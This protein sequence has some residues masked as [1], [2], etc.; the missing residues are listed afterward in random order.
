[1]QFDWRRG[2]LALLF[3][4]SL[5]PLLWAVTPPSAPTA[6]TGFFSFS[7]TPT[8]LRPA[9]DLSW[10]PSESGTYLMAGYRLFRKQGDGPVAAIASTDRALY[11]GS[12]FLDFEGI[13]MGL[14]YLYQVQAVD[15][16]GNSSSVSAL[17]E[18]D[19][20]AL[21]EAQLAPAAPTVF[22]AKAGRFDIHLSWQTP[23]MRADA[24]STYQ[25]YRTLAGMAPE[26]GVLLGGVSLTAFTD[27][28][29]TPG[30]LT[31]YWL[32]SQDVMGRVSPFSASA[33]AAA[34]GT[35]PPSPPKKLTAVAGE[36]KVDLSWEM[37]D[38]GTSP[39]SAYLIRRKAFGQEQW[40]S[41]SAVSVSKTTYAEKDMDAR[42]AWRWQ[43]AALDFEGNTSAPA[44]IEAEA[45]AEREDKANILLMPSAYVA[46]PG[47]DTGGNLNVA[48]SYYI[49]SLY[50]TYDDPELGRTRANVFQPVR[51]GTFT[52]DLKLA[53]LPDTWASP[54]IATGLYTSAIINIGQPT[55]GS[56]QQVGVTSSGD[57]GSIKTLGG[58]YLVGS[59]RLG[60]W[61]T[62]H[63]GAVRGNLADDLSSVAPESWR[64]TLRHMTPSGN[65]PDL[66]TRLVDPSLNVPVD[67]APHLAYV[68]LQLPFVLPLG[69][70]R[71]KSALRAEY[72]TPIFPREPSD[73]LPW[74]LN[75]HFDH[76]PLFGFEFSYFKFY[77]GYQILAF[78]HFHDL[79]WSL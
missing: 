23:A 10:E 16:K 18:M 53:L 5:S 25:V 66:M 20:G 69:F 49:G 1:M 73:K 62:L 31:S 13:K 65:L 21:P 75:V 4:F 70:T 59:K 71:W 40:S 61:A 67:S 63:A 7:Q 33:T 78:Y 14:R 29:P 2:I 77:Q 19:L 30:A 26:A 46:E 45:L 58:A 12:Q 56:Q 35:V 51:I 6:L 9:I 39:V 24:L 60:S 32:R 43:V 55:A 37:A 41:F 28:S 68:G 17:L 74:M 8:G 3:V 72:M 50:Q 64:L 47:R 11:K 15:A 54:G 38:A 79:N 44:Q 34:I 36:L 52:S 42:Q 27:L 57:D 22:T 76:L 48:F